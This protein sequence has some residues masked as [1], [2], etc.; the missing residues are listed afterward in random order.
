[1]KFYIN[2]NKIT[3]NLNIFDK[4][5]IKLIK[6]NLKIFKFSFLDY[7]TEYIKFALFEYYFG[8]RAYEIDKIVKNT[9]TLNKQEAEIYLV[10][11]LDDIDLISK[12]YDIKRFCFN[13]K[14]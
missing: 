1:M 13:L 14:L 7:L 12:I 2:N 10:K 11:K 9:T 4:A 3:V 8:N 6:L 5:I